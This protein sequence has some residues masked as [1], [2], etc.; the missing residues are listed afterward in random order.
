MSAWTGID[1]S[2]SRVMSPRPCLDEARAR[3][4]WSGAEA[5]SWDSF[6]EL[7]EMLHVA[8]ERRAGRLEVAGAE[9]FQHRAVQLGDLVSVD[10]GSQRGDRRAHL[11]AQRCPD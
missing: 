7:S 6:H 2:T 4:P 8:P 10:P 5:V 11:D 9:G 1:R 3:D